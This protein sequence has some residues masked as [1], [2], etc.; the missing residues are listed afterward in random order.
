MAVGSFAGK[1]NIAAEGHLL[2]DAAQIGA[3]FVVGYQAQRAFLKGSAQTEG[4]F[5]FHWRSK[6]DRLDFPAEVGVGFLGQ[7]HAQAG[8]IEAATL[9]LRKPKQAVELG[10]DLGK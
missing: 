10:F 2:L 5:L 9:Q 4:E 7:L 6:G 3:E 8:G 1:T